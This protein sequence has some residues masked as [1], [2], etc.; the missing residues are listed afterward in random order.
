MSPT[1]ISGIY[2]ESAI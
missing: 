2:L 1:S